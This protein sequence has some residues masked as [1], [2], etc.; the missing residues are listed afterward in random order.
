MRRPSCRGALALS[1]CLALFLTTS[2]P[3]AAA[4]TARTGLVTGRNVI[5]A[6]T[7]ASPRNLLNVFLPGTRL[8]PER[9]RQYL[10]TSS[11]LGF[12][13]IG[14]AYVNSVGVPRYCGRDRDP[15]CFGRV[16]REIV[17][18]QNHTEKI[19]VSY[20]SSIVGRL[21]AELQRQSRKDARWAQFLNGSSPRWERIVVS[22][23]SQGAAD[24]AILGIDRRLSRVILL[25]GPN[26]LLRRSHRGSKIP[27]WVSAGMTPPLNWFA[28]THQQDDNV[29]T[30]VAS[31]NRF[32]LGAST[33]TIISEGVH[34]AHLSVV[35]AGELAAVIEQRWERLLVGGP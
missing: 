15:N 12:H 19:D 30:Q 13:T 27:P 35:V 22:G 1:A 3:A 16:Q 20:K 21:V 31:W 26:D 4:E 28:L 10:Q 17:F 24:A 5:L 34:D 25:A 2:T 23:H 7:S 8:S 18:G 32:R 14:L 9:E 33:R 29:E 11:R 6:P